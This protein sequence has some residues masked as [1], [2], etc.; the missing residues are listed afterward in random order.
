MARTISLYFALLVLV[1]SHAR[2]I[3]GEI[4]LLMNDSNDLHD[5]ALARVPLTKTIDIFK[6]TGLMGKCLV[7]P[8]SVNS[9]ELFDTYVEFLQG[10]PE[11]WRY[12]EWYRVVM[13]F[14]RRGW[15]EPTGST[16]IC[17]GIIDAKLP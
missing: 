11:F 3:D 10:H 2:A 1:V 8:S 12:E 17:P 5:R 4:W 13:A 15:T 7:P 16:P 9:Q 14:E 6:H